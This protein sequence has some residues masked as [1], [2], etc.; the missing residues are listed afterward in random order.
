MV[1]T[2]EDKIQGNAQLGSID[3]QCDNSASWIDFMST[4]K[5]LDVVYWL[6]SDERAT[7]AT[8]HAAH[9]GSTWE[10]HICN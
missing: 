5:Q 8:R 3:V 10:T 2:L 7:V 9:R 4:D 6:L 1:P